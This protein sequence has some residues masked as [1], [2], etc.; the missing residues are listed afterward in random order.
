MGESAPQRYAVVTGSNKGI[1]FEIVK[2]LASSGIKVVL[3]ARDEQ[4]GLQALE[5]LKA[6]GLSHSVVFH[7]LDVADAASVATLADFLKSQ[8]GKLDILVN[9]AGVSGTVITDKDLASVLISNPGALS[10]DEKKKAVTQTY[11]LAEECLKI[12]FYGTKIATES[13]LPLLKLS[14]SPRVLNVSSTLGKLERIQNEWT[15]KVFGDAD[16]L[17]EEKVDEVLNKFLEDFKKDGPKL[18]GAY[19]ISK[20]AVNAYTRIAAKNFP[21][22]SINSVCPGYVITDITANTGI[23]TAEE[24]AASVVKLALLPNGSSSGQFY[25]RTE[26][27]SF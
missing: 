19:V 11:E 20:A 13:L 4:R 17:T 21:A 14:D 8:F 27:S 24:G 1:G 26:V 18:G 22:I 9:N 23:L 25:N 5:K 3:T 2:Q 16:N 6:S 15:K 12:N 7:Q 10:E